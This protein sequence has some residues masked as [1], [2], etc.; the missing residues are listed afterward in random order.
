MTVALGYIPS[1]V[2]GGETIW[3]AAANAL[4]GRDDIVI[5][6]CTPAGGY[7]LAYSFAA[8]TPITVTAVANGAN[9]GWTLE[10]S[11]A[12][13]LAF[14]IGDVAYTGVATIST[15]SFV[16]DQGVIKVDASPLRVSSWVAVLAQVDA[17]IATY[18]GSPNSSMSIEGMSVSYRSMDQLMALRDYVNH[19]LQMDSSKRVKRIIRTEFTIR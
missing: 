7:A 3:V 16:V 13:T 11:G 6:D 17:A 9:T 5:D 18:A 4:Q 2:V 15:R 14:P 12:Q 1:R 8:S 10:V 19:R